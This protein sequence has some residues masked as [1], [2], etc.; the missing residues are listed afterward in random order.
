[1]AAGAR[2][3]PAQLPAG[4]P[5]S[6]ILINNVGIFDG[7]G[8]QLTPGNIL[9]SERKIK[10]V[11]SGPIVP[12]SD[13][14]I[15][16]G[17]GR[18]LMPGLTDAH[19][20]MTIAANTLADMQQADEGL[21]YANTVAEARNTLLRGFT[22]VRDVAGPTFGIKTAIDNGVIPGPRVYP[23]GAM[24]SQ[25]AGHADFAPPYARPFILGGHPSRLEE[26]GVFAVANGVPEVLAAVR[27]QLKKGATQIKLAVGGGV[28]SDFDPMDSLQFTTEEIRAAVEAASDWGTYVATHVYAATGIR[29]ALEAGVLS[30]EHGHLADEPAVRLIAEKGAWLSMQPFE[31]ADYPAVSPKQAE[32][33]KPMIGA[34]E[35]VL[36]WAKKYGVKVAFGTDL[37]FQPGGTYKENL[38]LTRFS[39]IY[40]NVETLRIATAGNCQ[41]FAL[42]GARNP[43]KEAK[44]GVIQEG[45]WADMLLV[46]GDPTKDI[47]ILKDYERNLLVIIKDGN[48]YKNMIA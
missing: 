16:D 38:L 32:K 18:V 41:L 35:R 21:M 23:S 4:K 22:T 20:H 29:R 44:L 3:Q 39:K 6:A 40:S 31:A 33:G 9:V 8:G 47:D 46:D 13:A 15:I 36:G 37:L 24:I 7:V 34:W 26:I 2:A 45:A 43:Y 28:I 27:E 25:T 48:I 19:W 30:I 11:A 1:M 10:Q 42:S 14:I 17:R 5:P 12:P